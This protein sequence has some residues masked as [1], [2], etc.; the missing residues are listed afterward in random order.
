MYSRNL[1]PASCRLQPYST[2]TQNQPLN[3]HFGKNCQ[4]LKFSGSICIY[5]L[6]IA[7]HVHIHKK[8]IGSASILHPTLYAMYGHE[9]NVFIQAIRMLR[10]EDSDKSLDIIKS[11]D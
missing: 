7:S 9:L 2:T 4:A 3:G 1:K 8:M 5:Y 10:T 11:P 6:T